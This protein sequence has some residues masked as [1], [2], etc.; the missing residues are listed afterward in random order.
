MVLFVGQEKKKSGKNENCK[1]HGNATTTLVT[2][3]KML[4]ILLFGRKLKV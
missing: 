1:M 2:K 4:S 3:Q